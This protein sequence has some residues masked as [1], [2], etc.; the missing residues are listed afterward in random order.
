[1]PWTPRGRFFEEFDVGETFTTAARTITEGDVSLFAGLS[2][3]YNPLHV[4]EETARRTPLKGRIAHG[5]LTLAIATGQANQLGIF[6]GTTLALLGMDRIR[7]V[8]AVRHG[9]TIH[10]ELTVKERKE[11]AKPDRGTV[12]FSVAVLN[13]REERVLEAEWTLL[14][15]RGEQAA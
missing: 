12:V 8:G 5:T 3:D 4:D 10:T 14:L 15:A 1:M 9:D 6:E 11:S 7:F 2:G 13:Q